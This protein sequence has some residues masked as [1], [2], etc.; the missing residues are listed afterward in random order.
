MSFFGNIFTHYNYK[1]RDINYSQEEDLLHIQSSKSQ[2]DVIINDKKEEVDLPLNSPFDDWKTARRF[3]GPLPFTF[4]YNETKKEV[5]IIERVRQ[6]WKPQ[7]IEIKKAEIGFLKEKGFQNIH[8]ANAFK[9]SNIP[10]YWKKERL[11]NG[12]K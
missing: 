5:L 7:P 6:N 8:L 1:T 9:V 4:T 3:T 11:N 2:L 10:Y 12:S